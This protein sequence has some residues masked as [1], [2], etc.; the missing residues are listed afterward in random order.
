MYPLTESAGSFKKKNRKKQERKRSTQLWSEAILIFFPTW[1]LSVRWHRKHRGSRTELAAQTHGTGA[2]HSPPGSAWSIRE[3][4]DKPTT[5]NSSANTLIWALK[6]K[7]F[8]NETPP[9]KARPP[10]RR[11]RATWRN[12]WGKKLSGGRVFWSDPRAHH[13]CSGVG[14][15]R[16]IAV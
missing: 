12:L 10:A 5:R 15:T 14:E 8:M 13:I 6:L 11:R 1:F 16:P 2:Q 7:V 9:F 4:R 3:W